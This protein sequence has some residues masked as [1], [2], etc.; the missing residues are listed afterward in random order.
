LVT[1][2][3]INYIQGGIHGGGKGEVPPPR[4]VKGGGIAPHIELRVTHFSNL[5]LKI[6]KNINF[7]IFFC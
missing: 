5:K 4:P 1:F 6:I 2:V 7:L 3:I